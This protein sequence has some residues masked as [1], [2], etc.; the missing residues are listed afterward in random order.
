[1]YS[2]EECACHAVLS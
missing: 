1:M 2:F